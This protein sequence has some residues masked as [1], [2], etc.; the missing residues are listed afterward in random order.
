MFALG[1][2]LGTYLGMRL[3]GVGSKF[4]DATLFDFA[5]A[6]STATDRDLSARPRLWG[7]YSF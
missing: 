2:V 7:D 6:G 1:G 5:Q 3:G 4:S